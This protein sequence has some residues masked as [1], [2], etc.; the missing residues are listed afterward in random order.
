MAGDEEDFLVSGAA[1]ALLATAAGFVAGAGVDFA[2]VFAE[3]FASSGGGGVISNTFFGGALIDGPFLAAEVTAGGA[4]VNGDD[5]ANGFGT[6]DTE[7]TGVEGAVDVGDATTGFKPAVGA[8]AAPAPA[9]VD[10]GV[11]VAFDLIFTTEPSFGFV[12][13]RAFLGGTRTAVFVGGVGPEG[14]GGMP[15]APGT[16]AADTAARCM[17]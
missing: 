7:G 16:R 4:G 3:V 10:A 6:G 13:C 2:A 9:P 8:A 5:E 15:G 17:A 12:N 14:D 11:G 1:F